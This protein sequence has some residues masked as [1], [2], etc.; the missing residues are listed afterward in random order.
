MHEALTRIQWAARQ[1]I[2]A[3]LEN[4][5]T[6]ES[7]LERLQTLRDRLDKIGAD[8]TSKVKLADPVAHSDTIRRMLRLFTFAKGH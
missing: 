2:G 3:T 5:S 6:D 7:L 8:E 1:V 4:I